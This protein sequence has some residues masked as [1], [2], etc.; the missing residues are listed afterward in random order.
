MIMSWERGS[1]KPL[2]H[3]AEPFLVDNFH[4][5]QRPHTNVG[6]FMIGVVES[7]DVRLPKPTVFVSK[8]LS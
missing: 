3:I 6:A 5:I 4:N 1:T 7:P 2:F 8:S